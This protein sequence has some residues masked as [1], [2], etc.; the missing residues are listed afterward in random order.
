MKQEIPKG[1]F[2]GA[3]VLG[4]LLLGFVVF[5]ALNTNTTQGPSEA[6][7]AQATNAAKEFEAKREKEAAE[8]AAALNKGQAPPETQ[9]GEAAARGGK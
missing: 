8:A 1:A 6:D 3:I 7:M 9:T 2:I 4:V 5:R